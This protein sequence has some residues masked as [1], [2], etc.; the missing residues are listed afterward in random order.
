MSQ[1]N[2]RTSRERALEDALR[3]VEAA[4]NVTLASS[5]RRTL[6]ELRETSEKA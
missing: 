6:E 5:I 1:Q 3:A 2:N 4:G